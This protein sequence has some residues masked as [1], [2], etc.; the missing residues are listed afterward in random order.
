MDIVA[1][2]VPRVPDT[3]GAQVGPPHGV[4]VATSWH[5]PA[6][7]QLPV[8]PQ[9]APF[10]QVVLSRGVPLAAMLL[11]VPT[12]EGKTQLWHAPLQTELQHT[13]SLHTLLAQSELALQLWPLGSLL[14]H[15]LLIWRQ[16]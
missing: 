1:V 12:F 2:V 8:F 13:P 6:P 3:G 7:L 16:V 11:H 10:A 4:P 15:R 5:A 14:P 9:R